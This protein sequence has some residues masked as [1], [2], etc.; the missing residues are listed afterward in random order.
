MEKQVVKKVIG[1]K[2][3]VLPDEID[4]KLPSGLYIPDAS[5]PKPN[6]GTIVAVGVGAYS[7]QTGV[8]IPMETVIGDRV[9]Y[10]PTAGSKITVEY[11]DYLIMK[12]SQI[13]V[14]L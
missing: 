3:I 5:A 1:D 14:V 10:P 6:T 13:D 9:S 7:L 2:V 4:T 12:E 11:K 8:L